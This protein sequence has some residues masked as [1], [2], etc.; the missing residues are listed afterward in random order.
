M[1]NVLTGY[2][3]DVV[4]LSASGKVTADDYRKVLIPATDAVLKRHGEV[5]MLLH[6]G[7]AFD[8]YSAGAFLSDAEFGISHLKNL[9]RTALVTD[10][11]W[12]ANGAR[13]FAPFFHKPFRVFSDADLGKA[14]RWLLTGE[15]E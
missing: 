5:R 11:A 4:A 13:L 12:I 8:G 6:F 10:V 1:L 2:P 15:D 14:R 9:G 7:E 3:D